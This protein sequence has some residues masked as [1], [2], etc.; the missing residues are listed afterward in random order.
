[1]TQ[2]K[3]WSDSA[4]KSIDP[5]SAEAESKRLLGDSGNQM[6]PDDFERE[7]RALDK[8]LQ[9]YYRKSLLFLISTLPEKALFQKKLYV[10]WCWK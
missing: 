9:V 5:A 7:A 8:Y 1:M 2:N 3:C 10:K 4:R 6:Q